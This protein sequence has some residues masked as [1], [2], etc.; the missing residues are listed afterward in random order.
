MFSIVSLVSSSPRNPLQNA[1]VIGKANFFPLADETKRASGPWLV[2][3]EEPLL[4]NPCIDDPADHLVFLEDGRVE[5]R[6]I[7]GSPSRKG[8]ASI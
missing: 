2:L 5:A 1:R 7:D 6:L 8:E 4:L 3:R